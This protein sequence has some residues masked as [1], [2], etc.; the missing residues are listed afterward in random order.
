MWVVGRFSV[1]PLAMGLAVLGRQRLRTRSLKALLAGRWARRA[2]LGAA[3]GAGL[4]ALLYTGGVHHMRYSLLIVLACVAGFLALPH[5]LMPGFG[6]A[7]LAAVAYGLC[8]CWAHYDRWSRVASVGFVMALLSLAL[9]L[10][11][12]R[13]FSAAQTRAQHM[14]FWLAAAMGT[15]L[16]CYNYFVVYPLEV[17]LRR[18]DVVYILLSLGLGAAFGLAFLYLLSAFSGWLAGRG[19]A[20]SQP[21]KSRLLLRWGGLF[22]I[23]FGVWLVW[24][25]AF[26]PG[27]MSVD[28]VYQWGQ[29]IGL[30]PL[31]NSH[32]Y[33]GTLWLGVFASLWPTPALY[34]LCQG[35]LM[36]A[37][38]AALLLWWH[39]K[40]LPFGLCAALAAVIALL[41]GMGFYS[42]MVWK[43]VP[44]GM[45][46]VW[47][48]FLF[49]RLALGEKPGP[50]FSC[51]AALALLVVAAFRHNGILIAL[52]CAAALAVL[53]VR[54]RAKA[55]LAGVV[56]GLA[57]YLVVA[58]PLAAVLKVKEYPMGLSGLAISAVGTAFYHGVDMP[59]DI[60]A[61][62]L[63]YATE[64]E[65][66]EGYNPYHYFGYF[67]AG[68]AYDNPFIRPYVEKSAPEIVGIW[69]RLFL[70]SP[71]VMFNERM[72]MCDSVLFVNQGMHPNSHSTPYWLEI[73][74]N[75]FGFAQTPSALYSALESV[76]VST[77]GN[78]VMNSL[79]W[80][81]GVWFILCFWM[82]YYNIWKKQALRC[83]YFLPMAA[84]VLSLLVAVAEQGYRYT[85]VIVP[86]TLV[87]VLLAAFAAPKKELTAPA[88][89]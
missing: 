51:E 7:S 78:V 28:S 2:L 26:R 60:E 50:G 54:T 46:L 37:L 74:D 75:D 17:H 71:L 73:Y 27:N 59:P 16:Y 48:A 9:W 53:A 67:N 64:E 8:G 25:Y 24:W 21:G 19:A 68:E 52:L 63:A 58:G 35:L 40:G 57:L 23:L 42:T 30:W 79:F 86:Y 5:S 81:T 33:L 22:A 6:L 69:F 76:L 45:A 14:L 89:L 47:L 13:R 65:W 77:T 39:K 49:A 29:A 31:N 62:A 36:A 11:A 72:A 66:V 61:E 84:N 82:L 85:H 18:A 4:V 88:P 1:V 83:L 15:F 10:A 3:L 43:D 70:R 80:R 55:L 41:P 56:A 44:F 32:P 20:P 12:R 38:Y 87:G 34:T